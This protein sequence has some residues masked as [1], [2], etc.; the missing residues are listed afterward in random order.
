MMERTTS[1]PPRQEQKNP[2]PMNPLPVAGE[3]ESLLGFLAH[4]RAALR[5]A[6]YGLTDDQA[7]RTTTGSSLSI[8]GLV[9]HVAGAEEGWMDKVLG[10]DTSDPT[11]Y[12]AYLAGFRMGPDETLAGLLEIYTDVAA[13]TDGVVAGLDDLGRDVDLPKGVPWFPESASVRWILLHLIEETARHA[14]HADIIR[15]SLDGASAG[16]LMAAVEGWEPTAWVEPWTP[17]P[18]AV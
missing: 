9:K 17:T 6:A 10:T 13:R 14:G 16:A 1:D 4:Q 11:D 18:T 2:M 5:N 3:P 12:G 15:E 7:R 8:G